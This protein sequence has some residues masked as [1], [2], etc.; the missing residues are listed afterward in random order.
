MENK[1]LEMFTE[2]Y[3]V[4]DQWMTLKEQ[5]KDVDEIL[6]KNGYH[7]IAV[8]GMGSMALH[9]IEALRGSDI[10]LEYAID[11]NPDFYTDVCIKTPD[12]E[13]D[14]VDVVIY[15]NKFEDKRVIEELKQKAGCPLVSLSDLVFDNINIEG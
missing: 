10:T 7:K 9:L 12:E 11:K 4:L 14:K 8:Y 5:H 3:R 1:R 13:L 2:F 15:T 6:A